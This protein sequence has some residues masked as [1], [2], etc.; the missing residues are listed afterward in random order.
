MTLRS[1]WLWVCIILV[2]LG[3]VSAEE[4]KLDPRIKAGNEFTIE[5]PDMPKTLA[6]KGAKMWIHL[7]DDYDP[8]RLHPLFLWYNGGDGQPGG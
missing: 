7:P 6:Y 2:S 5:Y 8:K 4:Q 1:T 3:A